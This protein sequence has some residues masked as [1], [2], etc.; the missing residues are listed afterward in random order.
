MSL[1]KKITVS[2]TLVGHTKFA[3]DW[4]FGLSKQKLTKAKIGYLDDLNCSYFT[5]AQ[6]ILTNDVKC[7]ITSEMMDKFSYVCCQKS[8][9]EEQFVVNPYWL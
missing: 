3:P 1:H 8:N 7:R 5:H 4:C 9:I 6:N 2:F